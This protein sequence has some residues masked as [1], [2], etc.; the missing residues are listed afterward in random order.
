MFV[1][2]LIV[3]V[4]MMQHTPLQFLRHDLKKTKH[5]KTVRLPKWSFFARFR[6]CIMIQNSVNYLVLFVGIFFIMVM[7][8]MAVGMPDTL[9]YYQNNISDLM[10]AKYQYVF[11]HHSACGRCFKR[12]T[13]NLGNGS[14]MEDHV[15]EL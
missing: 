15:K 3:I 9:K 8:A 2:N 13:W 5:K 4:R 6:L 14:G 12:R 7:L 1:I 11:R 10:F